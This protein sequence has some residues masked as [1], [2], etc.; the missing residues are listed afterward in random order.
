LRICIRY[1]T[2]PNKYLLSLP[3]KE[4]AHTN[5]AI[6]GLW[7][8]NREKLRSFVDKELLPAWGVVSCATWYWLK[9]DTSTPAEHFFDKMQ[10]FTT[11]EGHVEFIFSI[12]CWF[13]ISS[14][15]LCC[16]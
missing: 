3:L 14:A 7:V 8:T 4:L 15:S 5:G 12:L 1:P 13:D 10:A 11:G 2:L 9:V 6:V 16:R